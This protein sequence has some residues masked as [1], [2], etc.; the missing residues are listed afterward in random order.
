MS[1][2]PTLHDDEFDVSDVSAAEADLEPSESETVVA[3][4]GL[5]PAQRSAATRSPARADAEDLDAQGPSADLVRVYLNGIGRTALLT[6]EQ[7][8]ELAKR[9][10]AG[11]FAAH[12]LETRQ[13]AVRAAQG[14][15]ASG[16]PRR[17]FGAQ[18]PAGG[19][20]ATGRLAGQAVHRPRYGRCSI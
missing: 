17:Q 8:V 18:P 13:P 20:S 19:E 12:K 10:E 5:A 1:D 11:V 7:E 6:A 2:S 9:I 4:P 16:D 15:P 3:L 14:G